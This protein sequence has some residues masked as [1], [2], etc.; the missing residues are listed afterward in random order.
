M[1]EGEE[2]ENRS[3]PVGNGELRSRDL[4]EID[5]EK[6]NEFSKCCEAS[7]PKRPHKHH[8]SSPSSPTG[9]T[10]PEPSKG[11][12]SEKENNF[13]GIRSKKTDLI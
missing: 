4:L 9:H 1:M 13:V 10:I 5:D 11:R 12:S 2:R 7:F 3:F 6:L 8:P